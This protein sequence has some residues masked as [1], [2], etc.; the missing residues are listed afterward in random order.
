VG[1]QS[2]HK[3]K[4]AQT[5]GKRRPIPVSIRSRVT[6]SAESGDVDS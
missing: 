1:L 6:Y 5:D 2:K 4:T 3:M